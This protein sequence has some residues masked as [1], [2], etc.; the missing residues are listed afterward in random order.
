MKKHDK[1][2]V[3]LGV[4]ILIIASIGI[5][6]YVP[7]KA[8]GKNASITDFTTLTGQLTND[9]PTAISVSDTNQFL[10]LI[11]TPLAVH[12]DMTGTQTIIPLYVENLTN[13]S[14]AVTRAMND[15]IQIPVSLVIDDSRTPEQWSL[16]LAKTFWTK[17][18][19]TLIIENTQQGYNLGVLATPLASY[20]SIP[21]I[22]ADPN[23]TA[24]AATLTD[25]GV[26]QA[27]VCGGQI[28]TGVPTLYLQNADAVV[29]AVNTVIKSRFGST[30]YLVITNPLDAYPPQVLA[31]KNYTLGPTTMHSGATT[32]LIPT[33]THGNAPLGTFTIPKD[34]KY[35][36]VKFKGYN[37]NIDHVEDLGDN[38]AFLIGPN[39]PNEPSGMQT[40]EYYAGGT[41]TGG[42]GVLDSTGKLTEDSTYQ[43]VVYYD[44]GGV[45]YTVTAAP[46]WLVTKTGQVKAE[47]TIE[48]LSSTLYPMMPKF[49]SLA[50]YLAAYHKGLVYGKPEFAFAAN[51]TT[52]YRGQTCPGYFMPRKNPRLAEASN[53]HVLEIHNQI[54][55]LLA[56][57]ANIPFNVNNQSDL[58][59][60]QS[61]YYN[62]PMYIALVGDGTMLPQFLYNS[63][64]EPIDA[65]K[66]M[67]FWGC[68]IPSD[69]IY[70]DIDPDP[71]TLTVENDVSNRALDLYSS[72]PQHYPEQE[73][74]IGRITGWDTQDVSAL[75]ARTIYYD[76]IINKLGDWK[77]K[78]AVMLG[79]GNDFQEPRVRYKLFGEILKITALG[80][81]LK[82][83]TGASSINGMAVTNIVKGLGYDTT[84]IRENAAAYQGFSN[85]AIKLLKKADFLNRIML[86]PRQL[87]TQLGSEVVK[88][89]EIQEGSNL[90]FANAHG[91]QHLF[92]MGDVGV[93]S[94][95]LGLQRGPLHKLLV[96]VASIIGFGPG[97]SLGPHTC[98][99]PRQ[100]QTMKLGPS[101]MWVE[102]CICGKL[103]GM[104]PTQSITQAYLH[105]GM[106][107]VIASTTSSNIAGGYLEPKNSRYD[108]PGQTAYR[109]IVNKVK[110]AQGQY[111]DLHFGFKIFSD[112]LANL[113]K[114]NVSLGMALR[115]ARNA[116]LPEDAS[117]EVWWSPPLFTS[118]DAA[119]DYSIYKTMAQQATG[120]DPRLDNKF[121]SFFEYHIFG[122]PAF[123]PYV[124]MTTGD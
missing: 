93:S 73:N 27:I 4:I 33:I 102:S 58:K 29:S 97:T 86:S 121:Q 83:T 52:L 9:T 115:D 77:D 118:G 7:M 63:S 23:T 103:D 64:I 46:T 56:Q 72:S 6:T 74:I 1:L 24:I 96:Q 17:S 39:L 92:T 44:R 120:K 82:L 66:M 31:T 18:K 109:Y 100:V 76:R 65:N 71:A 20:L 80:E 22:I 5:Y 53:A 122:D 95:G 28:N 10:P 111:P 2:I 123:T 101:F 47:V 45:E 55:V 8:T 49:S 15:Q 42:I 119:L 40:E 90:I 98:Y 69:F 35:S 41:N 26:E 43:E 68:G 30:D 70:S 116:Y 51:D 60:L 67:Y 13:P 21:V 105:S 48:K 34:Y 114:G 85:D 106:N 61:Y 124:P 36:L 78:A 112:M 113:Q 79:G 11:S 107:A 110:A 108:I 25:L 14:T 38:V 104:Y 94:L 37:M 91:N 59:P 32:M 54:N 117:W 12:Y 16:Y 50:P 19:A 3:V 84:Y 81:P 89:K 99:S 88:G 87:R 57:L 75:I 62:H